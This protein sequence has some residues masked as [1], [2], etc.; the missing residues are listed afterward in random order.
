MAKSILDL[1]PKSLI[2]KDGGNGSHFFDAQNNFSIRAFP[3]D[4]VID[5]TGAG[6]L[7]LAEYLWG[8]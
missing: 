1:G 3:V 8:K 5:T 6:V 7:I 2:I 4:K